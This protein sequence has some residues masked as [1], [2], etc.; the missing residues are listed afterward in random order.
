MANV[1]TALPCTVTVVDIAV[2]NARPEA[3]KVASPST[4]AVP[5]AVLAKNPTLDKSTTALPSKVSVPTAVFNTILDG[6][7]DTEPCTE[8]VPIA[9]VAT[10]DVPDRST[11]TLTGINAK[12]ANGA[13]LYALIP[14]DN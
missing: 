6:T 12:L 13:S 1:T 2:D 5:I 14:K 4:V 3:T 7:T 11:V 10:T 9:V 8:T